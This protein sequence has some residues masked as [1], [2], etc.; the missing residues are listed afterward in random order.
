MHAAAV[1][2]HAAHVMYLVPEDVRAGGPN[3][4]FVLI[5]RT[6]SS[7]WVQ[8]RACGTAVR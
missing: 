8:R 6:M 1:T 5:H 4:R 7:A 2:L 3:G